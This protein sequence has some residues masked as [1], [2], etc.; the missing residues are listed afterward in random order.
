MMMVDIFKMI[1]RLCAHPHCTNLKSCVLRLIRHSFV[2]HSWLIR[3]SFVTHLWLIRD[4]Y[5][6]VMSTER[7]Q[8]G[9]CQ[10]LSLIRNSILTQSWLYRDSLMTDTITWWVIWHT[11]LIRDSFVT[12]SWLVCDSFVTHPWLIRDLFVTHS[13]LICDSFVTHS[14][15]ICDSFVTHSWLI[16]DS[17]NHLTSTER[18]QVSVGCGGG[19]SNT[20]APRPTCS[21]VC[22]NTW[23]RWRIS[24]SQWKLKVVPQKLRHPPK[25]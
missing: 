20:I 1:C 23:T 16:R 4:R 10:W 5:Y 13:W 14:W 21:N 24:D 9:V 15:L 17:Y 22:S 11:S 8:V 6:H 2:T 18:A 19:R 12:H 25:S 3:D 7:A